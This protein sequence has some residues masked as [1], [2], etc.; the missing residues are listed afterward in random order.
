MNRPDQYLAT[1]V[2]AMLLAG[3]ILLVVKL[4]RRSLERK[5]WSGFPRPRGLNDHKVSG[6]EGTRG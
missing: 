5:R 1:S 3:V 2:T 4:Y 6:R